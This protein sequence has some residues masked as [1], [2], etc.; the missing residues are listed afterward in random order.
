[1]RCFID[2]KLLALNLEVVRR[3][4]LY[5]VKSTAL[6]LKIQFRYY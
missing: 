6:L 4:T 2:Y 1:M 3:I 5:N